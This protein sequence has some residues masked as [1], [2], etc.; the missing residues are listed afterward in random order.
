[1]NNN[2]PEGEEFVMKTREHWICFKYTILLVILETLAWVFL[3]NYWYIG[4][5]L[6]V[7]ALV[8]FL[9]SWIQYRFTEYIITTKRV[10]LQTGVLHRESLELMM[11]KCESIQV[12]QSLLGRILGYGTITVTT[13]EVT[14]VYKQV[15]RPLE[16]RDAISEHAQS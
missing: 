2:L 12:A 13:G 8:F 3:F 5:A 14:N 7:L 15:S 4:A 10:I 1:M 16:F 9:Y 6:G 11:H